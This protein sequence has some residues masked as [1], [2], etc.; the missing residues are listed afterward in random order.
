MGVP[1]NVLFFFDA[2]VSS[3]G[4]GE[5]SGTSAGAFS[6][7]LLLVAT[8]I[9]VGHLLKNS[10]LTFITQGSLAL[11]TGLAAG[12]CLFYYFELVKKTH[13]PSTLVAFKYEIYMDLLLPPIIFYAGKR[14]WWGVGA[15]LA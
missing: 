6:F 1:G 3:L 9:W 14:V 10:R 8:V 5:E 2:Y 12:G 7:L 4:E 13:I 15:S 11:V